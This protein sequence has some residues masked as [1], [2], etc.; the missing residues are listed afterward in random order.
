MPGAGEAE[1]PKIPAAQRTPEA[2]E[3]P[4]VPEPAKKPAGR[5][6]AAA[7]KPAERIPPARKP[8]PTIPPARKPLP[9][10]IPARKIPACWTPQSWREQSWQVRRT[11][12]SGRTHPPDWRTRRPSGRRLPPVPTGMQWS[13]DTS[14]A[15]EIIPF[16]GCSEGKQPDFF[17]LQSS[18]SMGFSQLCQ[19]SCTSSLSS[20]FSSRRLIFT[21]RSSSGIAV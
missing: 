4:R 19:I 1:P 15:L 20:R 6:Q 14:N 21:R 12:Q 18:S 16:K 13:I 2:A 5:M 17:E 8:E 9:P 11:A 10:R 7:R 3:P